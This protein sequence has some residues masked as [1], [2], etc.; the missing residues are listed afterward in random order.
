MA[1]AGCSPEIPLLAIVDDDTSIR[2]S[3]QRL[4]RSLGF[5]AE[6]FASAQ[7]FLKSGCAQGTACLILDLR[8]PGI[9]RAATT[10]SARVAVPSDSNNIRIRKW[11]CPGR[12]RSPADGGKRFFTST[13]SLTP[14]N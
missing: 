9:G 13:L 7:E 11:K 4:I 5:R 3:T 2:I 6:V 12:P 10:T 8:L 14:L 1:T